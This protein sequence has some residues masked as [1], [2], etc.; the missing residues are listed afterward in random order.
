MKNKRHVKAFEW[1]FELIWH[2]FAFEIERSVM[3]YI[4]VPIL[5]EIG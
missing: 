2:E 4:K 5:Y 1:F 3:Q